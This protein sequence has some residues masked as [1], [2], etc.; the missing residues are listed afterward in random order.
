MKIKQ[1]DH[2]NLSVDSFS[3]T[4]NW[5]ARVLGFELVEEGVQD[6]IRWG[7][8]RSGDAMLCI[9]EHPEREHC[10]RF[11]LAD[12]KL[13]GVAHF[14]VRIT[15]VDEWL[16]VL[17]REKPRLLYDG[18]ITWPNSRAWY[19]LDPTGY[20]IEVAYWQNDVIVF[21]PLESQN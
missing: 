19:I 2:L 7:V 13:H 16:E 4:T 8:I 20:E 15:D 9:Y 1:L 12:R 10:D 14:G 21:P 3:D 11:E 17:A 6:G 5:Y 18:E